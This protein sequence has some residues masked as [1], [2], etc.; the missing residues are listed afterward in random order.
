MKPQTMTCADGRVI[1]LIVRDGCAN[2]DDYDGSDNDD[3]TTAD[4]ALQDRYPVCESGREPK[5][6]KLDLGVCSLRDGCSKMFG[7]TPESCHG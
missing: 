4:P 6:K 2:L 3:V 5:H 7:I 1:K